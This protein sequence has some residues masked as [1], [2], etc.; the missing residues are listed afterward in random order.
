MRKKDQFDFNKIENFCLPPKPI[1][2]TKR[3]AI[4]WEKI[5]ILQ[6]SGKERYRI[7]RT[8]KAILLIKKENDKTHQKKNCK[9]SKGTSY[10]RISK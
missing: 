10:K 5:F 2:K 9:K 8:Y 3:Q 4:D 7:S 1:K 6:I